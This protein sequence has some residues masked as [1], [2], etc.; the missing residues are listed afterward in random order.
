MNIHLSS[1]TV[2]G[3]QGR[4][5]PLFYRGEPKLSG[6][7]HLE[8]TQEAAPTWQTGQGRH[9]VSWRFIFSISNWKYL[10]KFKI[11]SLSIALGSFN[12]YLLS[13]T[14]VSSIGI[15]C[16]INDKGRQKISLCCLSS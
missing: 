11:M 7:S 14:Y 15:F 12:K 8:A 3:G 10:E 13:G 9:H 2:L 16:S 1:L 4:V 6:N 5:S